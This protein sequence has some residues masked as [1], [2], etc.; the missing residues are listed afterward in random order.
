MILQDSCGAGLK[1]TISWYT[2]PIDAY[3]LLIQQYAPTQEA[4]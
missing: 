2:S 3:K 1:A 4:Q